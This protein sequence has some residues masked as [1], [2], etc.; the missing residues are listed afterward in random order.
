[1]NENDTPDDDDNQD[2]PVCPFCGS[3]DG[4]DHHVASF[5]FQYGE[6]VAGF[7]EDGEQVSEWMDVIHNAFLAAHK[8]KGN[9]PAFWGSKPL[10]DLWRDSSLTDDKDEPISLSAPGAYRFLAD[11]LHEAGAAGKTRE[12]NQGPGF[13]TEACD[14]FARDP[15]KVADKCGVL[16]KKQLAGKRV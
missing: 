11:L 2:D 3:A 15:E 9:K 1:M 7:L 16:L 5:D 6:I 10:M 13:S 14:L 12:L 8:T 4:C